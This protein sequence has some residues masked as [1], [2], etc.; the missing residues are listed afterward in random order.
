M[1]RARYNLTMQQLARFLHDALRQR[2]MSLRRF[3][4]EVGIS[5]STLS[6]WL[7]GKQAPSPESCRKM[8]EALSLPPEQVLAWAGHLIPMR[9]ADANNLPEFR[10]YAQR[11]YPAELDEDMIV[12]IEDLIQR[13]RMR[14]NEGR[15]T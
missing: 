9:K 5:P 7:S 15:G 4:Q 1:L 11:K 2:N 3:S 13:R 8:A 14:V 6:R 10:E 12:M